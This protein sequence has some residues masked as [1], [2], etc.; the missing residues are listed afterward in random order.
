MDLSKFKNIND[1]K[2]IAAEK[3]ASQA[4]DYLTGG[5]EDLRTLERNKLAYAQYQIRPRR[6]IDVSSIDMSIELFGRKWDT[7]IILSPVG[8]QALFHPQGEIATAKA[9][10]QQGHLM[11]A[12]TVSNYSYQEIADVCRV[13]PWFQLYP[14]TNLEARKTL[15]QRAEENGCEVL[16]LTIDVPTVGN[17]E[18]HAKM[19]TDNVHGRTGTMGNLKGLL[20]PDDIFHDLSMT[21]EIISWIRERTNMRLILKGI[22]TYE[23]ALLAM[24]FGVDGIIVSN[25]G[26]R[27]LESDMSTLEVLPEIV[28]AIG[29]KIPVVIDGGI[30]RGTDILKAIALGA[31]AVCIG[32]A[33]IYGLSVF[34]QNG[35]ERILAI[36]SDELE[37]NMRLTGVTKIDSIN[38]SFIRKKQ[39]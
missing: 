33:F 26:G 18:K 25:H 19:L 31:D 38:T 20:N 39:W 3:L 29:G 22:L 36:L 34:G 5:A 8:V 14:T 6:L 35:V 7:P 11:I 30:R 15:I 23:D 12:S 32:R 9:A 27:Q 4:Y 21:W 10:N 1:F 13:K 17:R 16:V 37:R 2:A 28:N 24:E